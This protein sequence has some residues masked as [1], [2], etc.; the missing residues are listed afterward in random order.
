[1]NLLTCVFVANK[2]ALSQSRGLSGAFLKY[3]VQSSMLCLVGMVQ[4][5]QNKLSYI[6]TQGL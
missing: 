1:M 4:T 3:C 5:I 2:C 6:Q